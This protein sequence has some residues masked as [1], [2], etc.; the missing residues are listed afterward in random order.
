MLTTPPTRVILTRPAPQA[1]GWET[2][3][4]EAGF[5][6]AL[7]PL[8]DITL[9]PAPT[10]LPELSTYNAIFLV[11]R[12]A[13]DG[14]LAWYGLDTLQ[15][16]SVRWLCPG[17]GTAQ[18]LVSLGIA[19]ER[20]AQPEAHAPQDTQH[21]WQA[22]QTNTPL[23]AG[24]QLLVIKGCDAGAGPSP[25]WLAQQAQ[26]LGLLVQ[27]ITTYQRQAPDFTVA[28]AELAISAAHD[29]S[30]W[31]F[32]SSLAIAHLCRALP[33]IHF[34]ATPCIA[35]HAR[36]AQTAAQYGFAPRICQPQLND[37]AHTLHQLYQAK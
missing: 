33:E 36:I 7:L 25:N 31:L 13:L 8:I 18:Q 35:T 9:L 32:S 3:L 17:A 21:L 20:I 16:A 30:V 2:A 4:A 37:I 14:L 11:S 19:S 26:Q 27:E 12:N 28:Q 5:D 23:Q 1:Q 6:V 15:T 29:G 34:Q 22:L 10:L 24:E